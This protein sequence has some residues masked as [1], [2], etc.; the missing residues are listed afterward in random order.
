LYRKLTHEVELKQLHRMISSRRLRFLQLSAGNSKLHL[1]S[2]RSTSFYA[3]AL[4]FKTSRIV[5]T[6]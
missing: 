5:F 4:S 3:W 6:L 1:Y 2:C